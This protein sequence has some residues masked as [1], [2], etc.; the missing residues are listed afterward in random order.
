[1]SGVV[2]LLATAFGT[3][4]RRFA[5][6]AVPL[7]AVVTLI[8]AVVTP[9]DRLA[10]LLA[11]TRGGEL[12]FYEESRGA[13][14]AVVEQGKARQPFRRLYIQGVSNSGDTMTSL[15]YMR[16]QALLPLL[17]HNGAPR[18]TLV[19]GLGTGITAG[20][21]LQYPGLEHRVVAELLPAVVRAAPNFQGNYGV[22]GDKR[23]DIRLRDGRRELLQ[24]TQR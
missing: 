6:V 18:S 15:R 17:I 9:A 7:L 4:V 19:I 24:S 23:V 12:V 5:R 22:T 21:L 11:Q 20:A 14:V 8:V 10:A 1:A 13:T 2:A 16:L 3:G